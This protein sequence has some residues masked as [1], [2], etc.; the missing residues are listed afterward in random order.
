M[1]DESA[2]IDVNIPDTGDRIVLICNVCRHR[3]VNMMFSK[4]DI[5]V[6]DNVNVE[7]IAADKK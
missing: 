3:I 2:V 7:K 4:N 6:S 5:N 1:Q